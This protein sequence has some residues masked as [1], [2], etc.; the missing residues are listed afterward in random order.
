[1]AQVLLKAVKQKRQQ[2]YSDSNDVDSGDEDNP[3]SKKKKKQNKRRSSTKYC[4]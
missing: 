1:M 2:A 4:Q 3:P